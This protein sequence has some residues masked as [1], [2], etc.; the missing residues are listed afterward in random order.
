MLRR[1][2]FLSILSFIYSAHAVVT[3]DSWRDAA[4][5]AGQSETTQ[6]RSEALAELRKQKNLDQKLI[7]ALDTE[8]RYLA[9]EAI[10]ALQLKKLVPDLLSKVEKDIDGFLTLTLSSLLDEANKDKVLSGY[11]GLLT[12]KKFK[13]ISPATIVAL[14]EP[15]GRIG[16]A[17]PAKSVEQMFKHKYPEVRSSTLQYVRSM[18]L[19]HKKREYNKVLDSGI[20]SAEFQLRLQT[21]SILQELLSLNIKSTYSLTKLRGICQKEK[22]KNARESCLQFLSKGG[23]K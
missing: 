13:T 2:L 9:L 23:M 11:S 19:A 14:L 3:T 20:T 4:R 21:I 16:V 5:K 22:V 1:I 18:A 17:L 8:D 7:L 6:I 12:S 15:L 10:S